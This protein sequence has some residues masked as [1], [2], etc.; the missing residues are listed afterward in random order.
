MNK[1]ITIIIGLAAFFM[2]GCGGMS[3]FTTDEWG[4]YGEVELTGYVNVVE[5]P[6]FYC[7]GEDCKVYEYAH[8][9]VLEASDED[10]YAMIDSKQGNSF[11]GENSV[12][13]GCITDGVIEYANHSDK[14]GYQEIKLS[15]EDSEVILNATSEDLIT[16]R[17]AKYPFSIGKGVST[18]YSH[19]TTIELL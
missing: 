18:C 4:Y 14:F 2:M 8:F 13:L 7:N 12:G 19:F 10:V 5:I 15:A 6:E 1:K 16:I 11:F 3:D 9:E 17:I